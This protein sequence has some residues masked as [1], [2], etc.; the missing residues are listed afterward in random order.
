M[1]VPIVSHAYPQPKA[2]P[3]KVVKLIVLDIDEL[4]ALLEGRA[5]KLPVLD[6]C[7]VPVLLSLN[8]AVSHDDCAKLCA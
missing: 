4:L 8:E 3:E 2:V 7:G 5:I 1:D 6:E